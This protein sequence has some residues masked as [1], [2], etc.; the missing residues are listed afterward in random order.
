MTFF[1]C[2][3]SSRTKLKEINEL[4]YSHSNLIHVPEEIILHERTLEELHLDSNR[5]NEIPRVSSF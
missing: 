4:N 1:G 3:R 5:I 2:T